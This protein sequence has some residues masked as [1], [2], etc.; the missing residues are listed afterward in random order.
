MTIYTESNIY[1][2]TLK[3]FRGGWDANLDPDCFDDLEC[4]FP[5]DHPERVEGGA[6][7]RA[8]E[9]DVGVLITFWWEQTTL[10]CLGV[11]TDVLDGLT[12]E[13]IDRGDDWVFE[14]K[15]RSLD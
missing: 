11:D 1:D 3:Y 15:T 5:I 4:N 14:Y 9:Q 13:Q 10:A 7:I 8:S 6:A 2:I 12:R